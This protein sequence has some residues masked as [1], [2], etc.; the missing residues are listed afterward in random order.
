MSLLY[1]IGS[2]AGGTKALKP[3]LHKKLFNRNRRENTASHAGIPVFPFRSER[4]PPAQSIYDN[5]P[6]CIHA[7]RTMCGGSVDVA[8]ARG[9][10][11][12][13]SLLLQWTR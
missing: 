13:L 5:V 8:S 10:G 3:E 7:F 1:G 11:L 6:L 9:A 4:Q 12:E 2:W